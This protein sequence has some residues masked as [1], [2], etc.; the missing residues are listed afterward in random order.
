MSYRPIRRA[1][2]LFLPC[3]F[4][5]GML[6][7]QGLARQG[8]PVSAS[9]AIPASAGNWGLSFPTEGESPVGNATAADLARYDAYY[10]ATQGKRSSI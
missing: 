5:A 4:L 2:A 8:R 10:L 9:A 1:L 3:L 6:Y 7:L